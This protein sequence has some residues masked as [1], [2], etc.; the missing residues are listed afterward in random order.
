[1]KKDY[2]LLDDKL[3]IFKLILYRWDINKAVKYY[4]KDEFCLN[5]FFGECKNGTGNNN[6]KCG[7]GLHKYNFL[8]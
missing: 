2:K 8:A 1:M 7:F 6:K 4:K 3:N 5:Y